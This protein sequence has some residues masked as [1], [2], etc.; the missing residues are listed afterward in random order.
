MQ[1]DNNKLA[2]L[3]RYGIRVGTSQL[4]ISATRR[5]GGEWPK[6]LGAVL[7]AMAGD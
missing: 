5:L 2:P 6:V 4:R 1:F 7:Q 3:L